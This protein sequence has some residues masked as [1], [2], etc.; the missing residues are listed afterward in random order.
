MNATSA[1][2]SSPV[3]EESLLV[4]E[5]T[6]KKSKF[7]GTLKGNLTALFIS[8]VPA[9]LSLT[10]AAISVSSCPEDISTVTKALAI[11]SLVTGIFSTASSLGSCCCLEANPCLLLLGLSS[12]MVGSSLGIAGTIWCS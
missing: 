2:A 12:G 10:T 5:S 1:F 8:T 7:S 3:G 11:T 4:G 6:T 9:L